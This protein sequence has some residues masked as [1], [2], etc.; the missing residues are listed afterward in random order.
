MQHNKFLIGVLAL[1]AS[2]MSLAKGNGLADY[3][4]GF[5][6]G[7]QGGR[8]WTN[9]GSGP[10]DFANKIYDLTREPKSRDINNRK[11][12][13]K[14]FVG[15]SFS[16][17]F[18]VDGGFTL[19]PSN[20]FKAEGI[21]D[22]VMGT[23]GS[24]NFK[25]NFY[26]IDLMAKGILP[27]E[28][29]SPT[30]SGW[31]VYAKLGAALTRV[32]YKC[33]EHNLRRRGSWDGEHAKVSIRPCYALGLGYNFTDNFG[34][35]LSWSGVY[36]WNRIKMNYDNATGEYRISAKDEVPSANMVAIGLSYKINI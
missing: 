14:V 8:A 28:K 36:S 5:Y 4:P 33:G 18:S 22:A 31:N 6:I 29:L 19:Y 7:L 27:L 20:E 34:V 35:D 9:E 2:Q 13:G 12:G 11:F 25:T 1:A 32:K 26:T 30:L 16:P 17:Y 23:K 21:V 24:Y 3:E 15:Y 10:E